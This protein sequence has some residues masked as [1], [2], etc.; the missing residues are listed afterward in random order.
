VTINQLVAGGFNAN[1]ANP[2]NS[3]TTGTFNGT[4]T[5]QPGNYMIEFQA[6]LPG[7]ELSSPLIGTYLL[8]PQ[9]Q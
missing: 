6:Q 1:Q 8:A 2:A 9:T 4:M 7:Y 3:T 5:L